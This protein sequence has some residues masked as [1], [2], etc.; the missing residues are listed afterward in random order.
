MGGSLVGEWCL[1]TLVV[2][3]AYEEQSE[4]LLAESG[5]QGAARELRQK[6]SV[7]GPS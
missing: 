1:E 4:F 6:E 5:L 3:L 2:G 7:R